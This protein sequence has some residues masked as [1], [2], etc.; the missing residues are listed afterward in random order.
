MIKIN[1]KAF[2]LVELL[3]VVVILSLLG[4][5][6]STSITKILK[7]SKEDLYQTQILAIK[8]AAET[9]GSS[10]MDKLPADGE[11]KY[12]TLKDLK[13][14]GSLDSNV[15]D[16]RNSREMPDDLKIKIT[17]RTSKF[18]TL[19]TE[20]EVDS[21]NINNCGY[22]YEKICT[23][24]EGTSKTV[25][26]KYTCKLDIDRTFY[27][28]ENDASSNEVT[29]IMNQNYVEEGVVPATMA[30]CSSGSSNTCNHNGLNPYIEKIK[31]KFGDSITVGIPSKEQ[32]ERVGC[33]KNKEKSCPTWLYNSV[34][35]TSNAEQDVFDY[36]T[37]DFDNSNSYAAWNV[38]HYGSLYNNGVDY[39]SGVG[40]RPVIILSKT[41]LS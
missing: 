24:V 21:K 34:N 39:S 27:V 5:I 17:S 12:L 18:G 40:L 41:D 11:C 10:N 28:L 26:A 35:G 30:W 4:L 8:S 32:L 33:I 38:D 25:G 6:A 1:N 16:S 19:I 3:A 37:S 13:E 14:N 15:I 7:D 20:Y 22:V 29:L 36:W 23:L 31:N 2:T 9:W